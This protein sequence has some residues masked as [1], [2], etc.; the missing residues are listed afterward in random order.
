MATVQV[1]LAL[2]EIADRSGGRLTPD[3]VV[4]EAK[5]P[6]HPLHDYF[7]WDDSEAAH[8]HRIHEARS[9]I[10]SVRVQFETEERIISTVAYVR[11]PEKEHNEQGYVS[12]VKLR[13]EEDNAREAVIT[14]FS[15]VTAALTRAKSVAA[16][17]NL[18]DEIKILIERVESVRSIIEFRV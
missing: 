16:V 11:D 10:R 2:K 7:T 17:L 14:E 12:I 8:L 15:R 4:S 6:K 18:S 5:N 3:V 1:A 13:T 9:L